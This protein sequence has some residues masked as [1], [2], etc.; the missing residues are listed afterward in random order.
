[1]SGETVRLS[2]YT[3]GAGLVD[4]IALIADG[5]ASKSWV[6]VT[7]GAVGGALDGVAFAFDPIGM[8]GAWAASWVMEHVQP[9]TDVLNKVGGDPGAVIAGAQ[10]FHQS[11]DA[12]TAQAE[13]LAGSVG[14]QTSEW[15]GAAA[16]AYRAHMAQRVDELRAAAMTARCIGLATEGAGVLVAAV[17][18]MIRDVIAQVVST[19][20][21]RLPMW[22]AAEGVTLGTATPFIVAQVSAL[23]ANAMSKIT[24]FV[25]ALITS[26]RNL[27]AQLARLRALLNGRTV[28]AVA[29]TPTA[30]VPAG[31]RALLAK[32]VRDVGPLNVGPDHVNDAL[33]VDFE[34][35]SHAIYKPDSGETWGMRG[36][37]PN[38]G[39][40]TREV[41]AYRLDH[42]L[43]FDLVPP[44]SRWYGPEGPGSMQH[45][46]DNAAPPG[47]VGQYDVLD[48]QRMAVLDYIAGNTDRHWENYLTGPD[49]RPV[50]IDNGMSFPTHGSDPIR[51]D[52]IAAHYNQPLHQDILDQL[53]RVNPAQL[54]QDLLGIRLD[55]QSVDGVLQRLQEIQQN[56]R[57]TGQA[58]PGNLVDA[59]WGHVPGAPVNIP[60]TPPPY[61]PMPQ[62]PPTMSMPTPYPPTLPPPTLPPPTFVPPEATIPQDVWGT[63]RQP[64]V[65]GS[66]TIPQ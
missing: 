53:S 25:R 18:A 27:M 12:L 5:I 48:Q 57:I 33:R 9:L 61:V 31:E 62:V 23:C 51:S 36:N 39:Q 4:D 32:P 7:L 26:G 17:R 3:A 50:A 45:W 64:D 28:R 49:G 42:N 35:G 11:A 56:G 13:E 21:I 10:Q 6:D 16:E 14:S 65:S 8:L 38:G 54:E 1:V 15:Q 19:L 52:F 22:L 29:H 37:I 2:G 30:V 20:L 43:G 55:R 24:Q 44:T 47:P 59:H 46:L 63:V 60:S 34:D 58:W 41:A 66:G 40:G